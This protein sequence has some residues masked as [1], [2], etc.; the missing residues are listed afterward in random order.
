MSYQ[1]FYKITYWN[2]RES[3]DDMTPQEAM[4]RVSVLWKQYKL[5]F[6]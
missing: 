4:K 3:N 5:S 6:L 1:K 2:L